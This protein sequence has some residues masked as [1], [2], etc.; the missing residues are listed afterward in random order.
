MKLELDRMF[1][2]LE[3]LGAQREKEARALETA[4]QTRRR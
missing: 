3:R 1:W 4:H 2:L